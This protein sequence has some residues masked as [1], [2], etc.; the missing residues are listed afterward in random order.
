[1]KF[2]NHIFLI[3]ILFIPTLLFAQENN[4]I[5]MVNKQGKMIWK[6]TN[7]DAFFWGVNYTTPFAHAFRQIARVGKDRKKAIDEDT[8][9]F[10]RLGINAYRIHV[11]DCEIE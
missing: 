2:K 6:D 1:M 4:H 5:I 9:H 10:A 7:E 8:Y 11:W 3:I